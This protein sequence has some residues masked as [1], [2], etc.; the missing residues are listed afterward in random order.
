MASSSKVNLDSEM[1]QYFKPDTPQLQELTDF[2]KT[3]KAKSIF[4]KGK[5]KALEML[6]DND[7][8]LREVTAQLIGENILNFR[9]QSLLVMAHINTFIAYNKLGRFQNEI[10]KEGFYRVVRTGL[11]KI[12]LNSKLYNRWLREEPGVEN[13]IDQFIALEDEIYSNYPED[14][15][16]VQENQLDELSS[17][18]NSQATSRSQS[19]IEVIKS[20]V[21]TEIDETEN[22]QIETEPSPEP[23]NSGFNSLLEQIRARRQAMEGSPERVEPTIENTS[24]PVSTMES[25]Q[26][27]VNSRMSLFDAIRA[28]RRED[29]VVD[30][31]V[32]ENDLVTNDV[33]KFVNSLNPLSLYTV[34]PMIVNKDKEDSPYIVLSPSFLVTKYS[35]FQIIFDY[36]NLKFNESKE[37]FVLKNNGD[38]MLVFKIKKV[39]IDIDQLIKKSDQ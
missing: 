26:A 18:S 19:P 28:R 27:T 38:K 37:D 6:D 21:E 13:K 25:T 36:I 22:L 35:N 9:Q 31:A 1:N 23:S 7:F 24:Q 12:S 34:I 2:E 14:D 17:E 10:I 20:P 5:E 32:R 33:Y 30:G 15:T 39:K 4:G 3:L 11:Y 29:N 16:N 8:G